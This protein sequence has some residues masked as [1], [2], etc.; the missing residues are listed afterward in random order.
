[1]IVMLKF[2]FTTIFLTSVFNQN[3]SIERVSLIN[4]IATPE[5][6]DKKWINVKGYFL[7]EFE[8][9][10]LFIDRASADKNISENG[11]TLIF[12]ST[13]NR[14]VLS[15]YQNQYVEIEGFF[16]KAKKNNKNIF[17]HYISKIYKI[18][19]IE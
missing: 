12:D 13:I 14:N 8:N 9:R 15:N 7:N 19:I 5:K 3:Y 11:V 18:R 10:A 6:Y 2:F 4:L 16:N 17:T 1:M